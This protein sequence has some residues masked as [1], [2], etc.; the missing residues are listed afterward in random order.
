MPYS[1]ISTADFESSVKAWVEVAILRHDGEV[2]LSGMTGRH[3]ASESRRLAAPR[4]L[5]VT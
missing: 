5:S 3:G 2:V 1:R 4:P